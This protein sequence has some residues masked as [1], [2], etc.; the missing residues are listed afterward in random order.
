M[1]VCLRLETNIEGTII[2]FTGRDSHERIWIRFWIYSLGFYGFGNLQSAYNISIFLFVCKHGVATGLGGCK[3]NVCASHCHVPCAT[4]SKLSSDVSNV[5]FAFGTV[6]FN[7]S[8][9]VTLFLVVE[10]SLWVPDMLMES[11]NNKHLAA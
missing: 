8:L 9:T 5:M 4:Y 11:I 2:K 7:F 1:F 3:I 10:H 6:A